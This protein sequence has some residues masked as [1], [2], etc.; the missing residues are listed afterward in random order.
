MRKKELIK[1]IEN[2]DCLYRN[3]D[4]YDSDIM[5][6][7]FERSYITKKEIKNRKYFYFQIIRDAYSDDIVGYSEIS[8]GYY[9]YTKKKDRLCLYTYM[10]D[11]RCRKRKINNLKL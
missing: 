10:L 6:N 11:R 5:K 7:F 3:D 2:I 4:K 8:V 1:F 9:R